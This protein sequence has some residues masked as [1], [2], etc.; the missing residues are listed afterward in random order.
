MEQ[1]RENTIRPFIHIK[2]K[3]RMATDRFK[4][5]EAIQG[6]VLSPRCQGYQSKIQADRDR[7]WRIMG[8]HSAIL[9]DGC[10][11]PVFRQTSKDPLGRHPVSYLQLYSHGGVDLLCCF[12]HCL[13][14]QFDWQHE[15]NIQGLLPKTNHS[16]ITGPR[17]FAGF[18]HCLCRVDRHDVL[19]SHLSHSH[20]LAC[21]LLGYPDD[22]DN[23][24]RWYVS[25]RT[26]CQV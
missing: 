14:K 26:E 9:F 15:S 1:C 20:S 23:K 25:G 4:G 5:T 12:N 11:H 6:P 10:I 13:R 8:Y 21:A 22:V 2:P 16:F 19:F 7:A 17:R 3:K 24:R 18:F